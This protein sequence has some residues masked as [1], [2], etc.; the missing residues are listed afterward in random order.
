MKTLD[1][2]GAF[3]HALTKD[4][5]IMLLRGSL[6]ETMVL[7]DPERHRPYVT[8]DKKGVP[9]LYVKMNKAL[10]EL[11]K[12]ALEFYLKLRGELEEQ[13]CVINPYDPCMANKMIDGSQHTHFARG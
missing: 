10:Y 12:S 7:I 5:V 3:L 1:I 9:M 2:P 13:D 8:H 11:L 6:A 4:E